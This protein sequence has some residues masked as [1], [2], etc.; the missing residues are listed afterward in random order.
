MIN[1]IRKSLIIAVLGMCFCVLCGFDSNE[2]KVYDNADLLNKS[3]EKEL[4]QKCILIEEKYKIDIV[5]LTINGS[6]KISNRRYVEA[7]VTQNHIGYKENRTDRAYIVCLIDMYSRKVCMYMG[8]VAQYYM[9]SKWSGITKTSS[10][11]LGEK[12]YYEACERFLLDTEYY[13]GEKYD[14]FQEKYQEK[15]SKFKG[16]YDEFEYIYIRTPFFDFLKDPFNCMIIALV[17]GI[18]S[19][20][21]MERKSKSEIT[22]D[23]DIYMN[24]RTLR[25]HRKY[26][27]L[28]QTIKVERSLLEGLK[29]YIVMSRKNENTVILDGDIYMGGSVSHVS[30]L[31]APPAPKR[32]RK[33]YMRGTLDF[34]SRINDSGDVGSSSSGSSGGGTSSGGGGHSF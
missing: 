34:G 11:Y 30:K 13:I 6:K 18:A 33:N 29:M 2:K 7:F 8:G 25:I 24:R 9:D 1:K 21:I 14:E 5:I 12:Q 19:I 4:Q 3:Q 16:S 15:W 17:V 22:L 10:R 28:I 32:R 23:W 31:P 27:Q 20:V 26:D